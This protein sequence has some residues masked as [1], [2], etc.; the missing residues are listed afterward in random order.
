MDLSNVKAVYTDGGLI[1]KNPS[2]IGGSWAWCA[3]DSEDRLSGNIVASYGGGCIKPGIT[4]NTV[5]Y[6]AAVLA[7]EALP[8]G[9]SGLWLPDS[10]NAVTRL[11]YGGLCVGLPAKVKIRGDAAVKRLGAIK[12]QML[13][14]HP[15]KKDLITGI[16][17]RDGKLVSKW[18][19]WVDQE[20]KRQN[21]IYLNQYTQRQGQFTPIENRM[22]KVVKSEA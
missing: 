15:T 6:I 13:G 10:E 20:C 9:W 7:F 21:L 12:V 8:E 17:A 19:V 4:N 14:G 5:E 18:N 22:I 11:L 1:K 3:V 16:R 2:P